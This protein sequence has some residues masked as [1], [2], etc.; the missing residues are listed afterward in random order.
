MP[1][2][3]LSNPIRRDLNR[4]SPTA[5]DARLGDVIYDLINAVN[6]LRADNI[7]LR[8]KLDADT[9]VTDTTYAS[10]G[11][12]PAVVKLPEERR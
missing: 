8:A 10:L 5:H 12:L 9:G 1:L 2:S 4:M 11:N 7:A 6:M 3:R